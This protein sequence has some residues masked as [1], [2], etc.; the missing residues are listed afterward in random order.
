MDR[1]PADSSSGFTLVETMVVL[2]VIGL[3]LAAAIPNIVQSNRGRRVEAAA[4]EMVAHVSAGRQ[5][6]VA[7]RIPHRLVIDPEQRSYRIERLLNDSTWTADPD[8]SYTLPPAVEW[9]YSAGGDAGNLDVEFESR[10]TVRDEDAPFLAVFANAQGD[11][12]TVSLV[13]TGRVIV[14]RGTP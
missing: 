13:R 9:D 3:L 2:A 10:G 12:F 11:T 4:N 5:R 6:A 14:R 7:S 1:P 8:M